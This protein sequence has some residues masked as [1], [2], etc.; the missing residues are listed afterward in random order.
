MDQ[1]TTGEN[2][3]SALVEI[4]ALAV[5]T[6]IADQHLGMGTLRAVIGAVPLTQGL[7]VGKHT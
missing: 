5:S 2:W 4:I 6:I 1:S 3:G 7:L